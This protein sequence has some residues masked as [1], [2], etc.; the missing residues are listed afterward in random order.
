MPEFT[1]VP[2]G[3]TQEVSTD[4][5]D[6][7]SLHTVN[8]GS[9]FERVTFEVTVLRY[10]T[11]DYYADAYGTTHSL[12][13]TETGVELRLLLKDYTGTQK[14]DPNRLMI[15]LESPDGACETGYKLTNA[16]IQGK[17]DFTLSTNV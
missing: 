1:I 6:D 8:D 3:H 16:E 7:G 13:G 2:F 10:L 4:I 15:M 14:I 5:N 9:S 17:S 11:N 12:K